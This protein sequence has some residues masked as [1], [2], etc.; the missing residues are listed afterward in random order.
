MQKVV[1]VVMMCGGWWLVMGLMESE[2]DSRFMNSGGRGG[3][4]MG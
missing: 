3:D 1:H 2:V 4:K